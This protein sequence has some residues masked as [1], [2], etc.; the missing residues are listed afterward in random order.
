MPI[1]VTHKKAFIGVI[2]RSGESR[3]PEDRLSN[4]FWIPVFT[5]MTG[6]LVIASNGYSL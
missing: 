6:F 2:R 1:D 5:G 4:T 3:S